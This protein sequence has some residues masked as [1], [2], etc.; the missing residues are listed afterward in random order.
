MLFSTCIDYFISLKIH[1]EEKNK[2]RFILLLVSLVLNL[3]LLVVFKYLLF[4]SYNINSF[5]QLLDLGFKV[6]TIHLIL[7]LGISFYTFQTISY[8]ID[9]YRKHLIPEKNFFKYGTFV[10]FFPQ[11]VAGPILRAGEVMSELS[12]TRKFNLDFII[13]GGKRIL[14]G[15]FLKVVL[16]DNIA[17]IVDAGF[18]NQVSEYTAIDVLVLAYLFGFQIYFDFAGYSHIAIGCAK[19]MGI[20]FPENFN[21]PYLAYSFKNFWKRWH[22][23]LSSWIRDYLYLPILGVKIKNRESLSKGGLAV[24]VNKDSRSPTLA[25]FLTWAIMG[26]WHGANWTF[27]FWGIYHAF[28]IFIERFIPKKFNQ[29][30]F[31]NKFTGWLIVLPITMLSWIP[32]RAESL[33]QTFSMFMKLFNLNLY[34]SYS[35]RENDLLITAILFLAVIIS[36]L[37]SKVDLNS[38]KYGNYFLS[39]FNMVKYVIMLCLVFV[40]LRPITQFIYFQF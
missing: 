27:A 16:A 10:T 20:H 32:F 19:I 23:S 13:S 34:F 8:T 2:P 15:L 40:F 11:L 12:H 7:P 36:G 37:L 4:I 25:L 39:L 28:F 22:I 9:V 30:K 29:F 5:S 38:F 1:N 24:V 17:P 21:F 18:L 35:L 31:I 6:N 14:T 26:L 33:H 3:S